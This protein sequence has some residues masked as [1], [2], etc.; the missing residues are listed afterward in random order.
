MKLYADAPVR[1][2]RQIISD[3]L[4]VVWIVAWA[5]IA[6]TVYDG[7]LKLAVPG[8]KIAESATGLSTGLTDAG[9]RLDDV[10]LIGG[11]IA[12]PFDSA[13]NASSTLAD[14]G[15]AQ[16]EAV[17]QLAF[18]LGL[19]VL[20]IPVLVVAAVYLPLR[21]RFVRN[22]T[23]GARFIDANADLDLFALRALANQPMH[24]LAKIHDDP[25][26]RWRAKDPVVVAL[27][28]DL[29]L[30]ECGLRAKAPLSA[31]SGAG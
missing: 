5:W 1:R 29:E 31:G 14:A 26:G 6:R 23:A 20:L 24:V 17:E 30:R 19:S 25:A 28:A 7:T 15:Q 3:L 12:V 8:H 9:A 16:V 13:A 18:W 22:A 10:P 11:G 4:F 2:L 21:I 27:L